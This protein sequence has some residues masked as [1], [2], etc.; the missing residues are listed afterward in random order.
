[1][2]VVF[3]IDY[4]CG[5][6]TYNER[7]S[8]QI[9]SLRAL[10]GLALFGSMTTWPIVLPL[11]NLKE[12]FLYSFSNRF[13]DS[14]QLANN[15]SNVHRINFRYADIDEI[16]P[17]IHHFP[18]VKQIKIMSLNAGT[19]T[20]YK[21]GIIDLATLNNERQKLPNAR[22]ITMFLNEELF[23]KNKW[24]QDINLSLIEL[25]RGLQWRECNP[26]FDIDRMSFEHI[27]FD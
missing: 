26:F 20:Y 7:N 15:L 14:M 24:N 25:K 10:E 11:A 6:R 12:L 8:D 27:R 5:F 18:N 1:M 17:F 13:G 19:G 2:K 21:K 4:I 16:L 23:L 3:T 22:K 9:A